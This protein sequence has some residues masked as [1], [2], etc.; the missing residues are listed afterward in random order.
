L[1]QRKGHIP[2]AVTETADLAVHPQAGDQELVTARRPAREQAERA[3]GWAQEAE[4]DLVGGRVQVVRERG[5]EREQVVAAALEEEPV[6][7]R[8]RDP[9]IRAGVATQALPVAESRAVVVV[10]RARKSLAEV[11]RVQA[12]VP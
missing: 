7:A 9:L 3:P 10:V 6:P 4:R 12:A 1:L 8:E 2:E 11:D 5:M